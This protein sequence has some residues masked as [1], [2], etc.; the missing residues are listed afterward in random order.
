VTLVLTVIGF[1]EE[2]PAK[3]PADKNITASAAESVKVF[4]DF[5]I[6][7]SRLGIMR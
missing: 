5:V 2:A 6:L 1:G 3:A 7:L 4:K